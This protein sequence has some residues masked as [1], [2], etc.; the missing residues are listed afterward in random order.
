MSD[1]DDDRPPPHDDRLGQLLRR[2]QAKLARASA[3]ALAPHGVD[4]HELA[5]LTVLSGARTHSQVEVAVRLGVDRTTMVALIDG[6]EDQ[7][8]VRRR[9]SAQ[10]RRKNVV[11]LTPAGTDCLTRA[12]QARRAAESRFLAPLG[13]E[14]AASLIRALRVL[15]AEEHAP[16]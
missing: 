4:G 11:E 13:E 6:L 1:S 14:T 2:A 15:V 16:G 10:D 9:R 3:Q 12:E 8:L 7:G 5:V